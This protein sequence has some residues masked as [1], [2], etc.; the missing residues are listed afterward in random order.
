MLMDTL[1]NRL[2]ETRRR[3]GLT[4]AQVARRSGMSQAAYQKLES[5]RS[6][7]SRKLASIARTLNVTAEWL[8]AGGDT[9]SQSQVD[10][11]DTGNVSPITSG[12]RSVPEISWVQAGEWTDVENVEDINLSEVRHW[13][14]PVSCSART[15]A[16]RV[17]GDSM[18]PTFPPGSIIFVDPEVPPIS[19]KKVVAKLVDESKA[20]FKQYIEDGDSKLLKA[21]NPNWPEPYVPING[22]CVII[23]TVVFAGTEV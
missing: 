7:S 14:C 15:F 13:P 2:I 10:H 23:G 22:N 12:G 6:L 4:Q 17:E 16:L 19:G 9:P 18:A 3:I 5:G 8:E 20:T 1:R 11:T 21:M